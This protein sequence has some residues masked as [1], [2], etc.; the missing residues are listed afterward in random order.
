MTRILALTLILAFIFSD[1]HS[2]TEGEND[3]VKQETL[4]ALR[5]WFE[6]PKI[7]NNHLD[8]AI[9]NTLKDSGRTK[10]GL[11]EGYWIHYSLDTSLMGQQVELTVGDKKLPMNLSATLQKETGDYLHG[12]KNGIW[13]LYQC[14]ELNPPFNWKRNTVTNYKNGLKDGEE[15]MYQGYIEE[16]PFLISHWKNGVAIGTMKIYYDSEPY[17]LKKVYNHV[18]GKALLIE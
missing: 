13:T 3:S 4:I 1:C 16:K 12:K 11:K 2:Q 9:I 10:G 15:I 14:D 6:N 8:T 18:G 17:K 5:K 7:S